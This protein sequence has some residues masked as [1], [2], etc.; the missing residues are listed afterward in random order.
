MP[1]N[2]SCEMDR[3]IFQ[4]VIIVINVYKRGHFDLDFTH[5]NTNHFYKFQIRANEKAVE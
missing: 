4:I 1:R 3:L 2:E 5:D